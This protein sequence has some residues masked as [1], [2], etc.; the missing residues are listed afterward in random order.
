M[1]KVSMALILGLILP[2]FII[3]CSSDGGS[4]S[5]DPEWEDKVKTI[6][7]KPGGWIGEWQCSTVTTLA[8]LRFDDDGNNFMVNIDK[9]M[10]YQACKTK[11]TITSD[12]FKFS[13]CYQG[14]FQMIYDPNDERYP[15]KADSRTCN[16]KIK[17]K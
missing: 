6:L 13:G 14:A 11:A 1:K 4:E 17:A 5:I 12:G 9:I 2:M 7:L 15:F 3:S 16:L 10:E 8:G